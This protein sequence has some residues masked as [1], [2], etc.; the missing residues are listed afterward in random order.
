MR[1]YLGEIVADVSEYGRSVLW[2]DFNHFSDE[3]DSFKGG[4][5]RL[6]LKLEERLHQRTQHQWDS[7]RIGL[8]DLVDGL[9]EQVPIFVGYR[10]LGSVLLHPTR[11]SNF[12]L[13]E[14]NYFL[15]VPLAD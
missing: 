1:A 14:R 13:K 10:C 6:A 2:I 3:Q 7:L 11:P 8:S 15:D 9:Y 12:P 4:E 5:C